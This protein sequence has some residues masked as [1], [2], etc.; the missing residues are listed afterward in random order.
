MKRKTS[1][2]DLRRK[3]IA[4]ADGAGITDEDRLAIFERD[5]WMCLRCGEADRFL[6]TIDHVIPISRGGRNDPDNA[7]TLCLNCNVQKGQQTIDYRDN[8]EGKNDE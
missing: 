5:G 6:L 4:E 2:A 1:F 7:A 8:K 3:R